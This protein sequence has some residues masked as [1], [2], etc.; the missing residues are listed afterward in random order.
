MKQRCRSSHRGSE[1]DFWHIAW[2]RHCTSLC[3][4]SLYGK[5]VLQNDKF[6]HALD[7][8]ECVVYCGKQCTKSHAV[9]ACFTQTWIIFLLQSALWRACCKLCLQG[10][11]MVFP[12]KLQARAHGW[13]FYTLLAVSVSWSNFCKGYLFENE[14]LQIQSSKDSYFGEVSLLGGTLGQ[15]IVFFQCGGRCM[16]A[17]PARN[18]HPWRKSWGQNAMLVFSCDYGMF[19]IR[20]IEDCYGDVCQCLLGITSNLEF[21]YK[22]STNQIN[23]IWYVLHS[24]PGPLEEA[25]VDPDSTCIHACAFMLAPLLPFA[26]FQGTRYCEQGTA[27]ELPCTARWAHLGA[28]ARTVPWACGG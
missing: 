2:R 14:K 7:A 18:H 10:G 28:L 4:V 3:S 12:W 5:R 6:G 1:D 22:Q 20:P 13:N 25:S 16:W 26:M 11:R 8:H 23:Q 9:Q 21:W 27:C 24:S 19:W 15:H 17:A